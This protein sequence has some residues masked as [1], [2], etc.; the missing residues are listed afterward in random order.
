MATAYQ[1][2]QGAVDLATELKQGI[3]TPDCTLFEVLKMSRFAQSRLKILVCVK[4]FRK[5]MVC[6]V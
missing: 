6:V 5:Y 2:F 1:A 4:D 3:Q